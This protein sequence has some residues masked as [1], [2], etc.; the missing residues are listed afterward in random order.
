MR[1]RESNR[2]L[3]DFAGHFAKKAAFARRIG[4]DSRLKPC[5]VRG[6][7]LRDDDQ[8]WDHARLHGFAIVT[9]DADT[10]RRLFQLGRVLGSGGGLDPG[11][12]SS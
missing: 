12:G 10:M 6:A 5:A 1:C 4:R 9:K 8:I 3:R 2:R 7:Q 11:L